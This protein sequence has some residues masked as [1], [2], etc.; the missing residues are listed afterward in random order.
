MQRV[1]QNLNQKE[2]RKERINS[3][4]WNTAIHPMAFAMDTSDLA[5]RLESCLSTEDWET[6]HGL[7]QLTDA[8]E[9][10]IL[11]CQDETRSGENL[12]H[13]MTYCRSSGQFIPHGVVKVMDEHDHHS[14]E[15]QESN[16][17]DKPPRHIFSLYTDEETEMIVLTLDLEQQVHLRNWENVQRL[18]D[19][20]PEATKIPV[21]RYSSH[22]PTLVH[23]AISQQADPI[24][25]QG[26]IRVMDMDEVN[27]GIAYEGC[28][29]LHWCADS[30]RPVDV[31][32]VVLAA[33]PHTVFQ[34]DV[35]GFT[36]ID[37]LFD[38]PPL[39]DTITLIRTLITVCPDTIHHIFE[40][41]DTFL[42]YV[43]QRWIIIIPEVVPAVRRDTFL[44]DIEY[45]AMVRFLLERKPELAHT[46]NPSLFTPFIPLRLACQTINCSVVK[47]I[48]V[49]LSPEQLM[50]CDKE[51]RN[52]LHD[53]ILQCIRFYN[54]KYGDSDRSES[55][56]IVRELLGASYELLYHKDSEGRTPLSQLQYP[57][58]IGLISFLR[59]T[60]FALDPQ[61]NQHKTRNGE[62][63]LHA[64][65]YTKDFPFFLMEDL[66]MQAPEQA[67]EANEDGNLPLHLAARM[68]YVR[69]D[70]SQVVDRSDSQR[71]LHVLTKQEA[72][73]LEYQRVIRS[74]IRAYPEAVK[75]RNGDGMLPL[76][77]MIRK[78]EQGLQFWKNGI[79]RLN[80]IQQLLD[81]HPA[82]ICE[83]DLR[84]NALA[85]FL[86]R[87]TP[88]TLYRLLREAPHV[89]HC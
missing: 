7:I 33:S 52:V 38:G 24:T 26:I 77:L 55:L 72:A 84:G 3:I 60:V 66:V 75:T 25:L 6:L 32:A 67:K 49:L 22:T 16:C 61:R 18:V 34:K 59:Q 74:L 73:R 64:A 81:E 86:S 11:K 4:L 23:F 43:L 70:K 42:H 37:I 79:K 8:S 36:P 9:E 1:H 12:Q 82:A 51:G 87:L 30:R 62:L 89:I 47:D 56:N 44:R 71:G 80:E 14:N 88:D 69:D 50:A 10:R 15:E 46:V 45:P 21:F 41:G 54:C 13:I 20:V 17:N 83:L 31:I 28:T 68:N 27:R 65:F 76:H 19:T 57:K 39:L 85:T 48:M 40:N 78:G 53:A 35:F 29:L 63:F 5:D 2:S 58:R